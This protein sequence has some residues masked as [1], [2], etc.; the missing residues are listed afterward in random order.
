MGKRITPDQKEKFWLLTSQGWTSRAAA[1][2]CGFSENSALVIMREKKYPN[3]RA[4]N[5]AKAGRKIPDKPI[6][7]EELSPE[8]K[9]ALTDFEYFRRRYFGHVSSPWQI[10]A[11]EVAV[12]LLESPHKEYV[13]INCPPGVGKT[14]LFTHDIPAWLI[15]RNRGIRIIIG[16]NTYRQAEMHAARLRRSLERTSPSEA[17]DLEK[18]LGLAVDAEATLAHDFGR[19]K[20]LDN[21][22]WQRGQFTVAQH[23]E[24]SIDE[25]ESTVTAFGK[26]SG[27]LGWRVNYITWDDVDNKKDLRSQDATEAKREWWDDEAETRLEPAGVLML[28]MQRLAAHDLSKYCL[29]KIIPADDDQD[30]EADE[31]DPALRVQGGVRKYRH[32]VYK[33]HYEDRCKNEHRRSNAKPHPEGCLLDPMRLPWRE[34][35]NA[36]H[37]QNFKTV[38]QQEDGDQSDH[39]AK[40]VW[41]YGGLDHEDGV[42]YDGCIDRERGP[43]ELP[44]NLARPLISYATA[45]PSP[46]RYWAIQHWIFCPAN[47]TRYLMDLERRVMGSDEF[48]DWRQNEGVF[49]GVMH[50]WQVRSIEMGIPITHWIVE[51]N[52]AQRWL[53]SNDSMRRWRAKYSV[54]VIPHSTTSRKLDEKYGPW[55]LRSLYQHAQINLP[56]KNHTHAR[57]MSLK[58]IEEVTRWTAEGG[59]GTDDEVMAQWFGEVHL[60]NIS[61]KVPTEEDRTLRKPP[62]WFAA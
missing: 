58:L 17:K 18:Q 15:T 10:E 46:T 1:K 45:D 36:S 38:Y 8:A 22:I 60:E 42:W 4:A 54:N 11:A 49:Y 32:I 5:E 34:I 21:E 29:D 59:N 62:S 56:W 13:V 24:T 37:G 3:G 50:D 44:A 28:P 61:Y 31:L 40:D 9:R 12:G 51:N 14:T 25:K 35:R 19:F 43:L 39:L 27:S 16:S 26:D 41:I 2:K 55:R 33:A 47:N 57:I 52:A 23:G 53:L 30:E 48:L 7:T 20:P 6:P